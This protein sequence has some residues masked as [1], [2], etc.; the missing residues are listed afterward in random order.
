MVQDQPKEPNFESREN[1]DVIVRFAR[2]A[3]C[4]VL[5]EVQVKPALVSHS[6]EKA[7]KNIRKEVSIPGFRK[8]KAPDEVIFK[9][10]APQID[11][12]WKDLVT[13]TA[14]D[15]SIPLI[16]MPPLSASSIKRVQVKKCVKDEAAEVHFE[17]EASPEIPTIDIANLETKAITPRTISD[18]DVA[19]ELKKQLVRHATFEDL[20]DHPVADNDFVELSVDII[21]NPAQN[22]FTNRLFEVGRAEMPEWVYNLVVGMNVGESRE[23]QADFAAVPGHVH[24]AECHHEAPKQCRVT[25]TA[26]KRATLPAADDEFAKKYGIA[27]IADFR[28]RIR[29]VLERDSKSMAAEI[30]RSNL[31][32]E[33]LQKYPI[34]LPLSLLSQEASMRFHYCTDMLK[35]EKGALPEGGQE[36][37]RI[38]Y[39]TFAGAKNFLSLMYLTNQIAK[40]QNFATSEYELVQ[41]IN[42]EST[43]VPPAHRV[44]FPNMEP[45]DAKNRLFMRIMMR[46]ALDWIMEQK[47]KG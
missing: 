47:Q 3:G 20:T 43:Q 28:E 27:T 5:L 30:V 22:V 33:L 46:K 40:T 6:Y 21:E 38:R 14:F 24:T 13:R 26:I 34:E 19:F 35:K 41:E 42:F 8:G 9:N 15:K 11:R 10:F 29:A 32:N 37:E 1:D 7:V 45:Q 39:E 2:E 4:R 31:A 18:D 25:V 44:I 16:N 17:Y 36:E 23:G 12:E